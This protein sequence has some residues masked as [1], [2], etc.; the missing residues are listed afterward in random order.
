[1][2]INI[3]FAIGQKFKTR[4]KHPR[5]CTITDILRTYN[6]ADELVSIRYTATHD[7][8]GQTVSETNICDAT[9]AMG[10]MP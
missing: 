8:C 7:F 9:I 3:R 6:A 4:G 10:I 1:M 5:I 2:S